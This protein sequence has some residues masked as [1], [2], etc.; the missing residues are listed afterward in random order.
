MKRGIFKSARPFSDGEHYIV[1]VFDVAPSGLIV[2]A[3]QQTSSLEF[4]LAVTE[5]ELD[6]AELNRSDKALSRLASSV[7]VVEKGGQLFLESSLP[8]ISKPKIVP[9]GDGARQFLART[10]AGEE[11]LPEF[12]TKA[13]TELCKEKPEKPLKWLGNWIIQNNPNQPTI[14]EPCEESSTAAPEDSEPLGTVQ[15][16]MFEVVFV[17][18]GPGAGKG[19]QCSLI[20]EAFGYVHLSAGDLLRAERRDPESKQGELINSYIKDGKIVPVEITLN[21]IKMAMTKSTGNKFL[22]DGFPRSLD[23][24]EGWNNNMSDCAH[25]NFVLYFSTTE[26]VMQ[27]R[28]LNRRSQTEQAGGDVR[29]DDNLE[30]LK[31][32]FQTYVE[33]TMPIID[34]FNS[35]GVCRQIDASPP[36][37]ELV[38][39]EV[40]KCFEQVRPQQ[41]TLTE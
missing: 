29:A 37:P 15:P 12:L 41:A 35:L 32:R 2:K 27:E 18:G 20:S 22:I 39:A 36:E 11:T 5:G 34:H 28:I 9:S 23:N 13:L 17:L 10:K 6:K 24:L 21:L 31:K 8:G 30:S 38:F 26:D 25:L 16:N 19:T 14:R 3:Y 7:D 1:Q 40:S 33:S 4:V